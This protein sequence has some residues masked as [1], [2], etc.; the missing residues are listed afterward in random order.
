M[1]AGRFAVSGYVRNLRDGSV[2]LEAQGART[3]V[4]AFLESLKAEMSGCIA[5]ASVSWTG[6][7]AGDEGFAVRF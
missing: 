2:E 6:A 3:E 4:E 5:E 7:V 1:L